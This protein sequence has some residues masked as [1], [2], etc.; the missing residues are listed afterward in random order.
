MKTKISL[1]V[2]PKKNILK[3]SSNFI[4]KQFSTTTFPKKDY[5]A[6]LG[7]SHTATIEEVKKA[8]RTLAKK[9][10]P[11]VSSKPDTSSEKVLALEKFRDVAE[12]YA[13]LSNSFSKHNYDTT[14]KPKPDAVYNSSKMTAKAMED[15]ADRRNNTGDFRKVDYEKGSYGDFKM[16]KLKEFQKQFNFDHL[17][18]FK[19]GV[20]RRHT[21]NRGSAIGTPGQVYSGY[22]HDDQHAD[23]PIVKPIQTDEAINHKYF[24]L[25]KKEQNLRFKPYFNIEKVNEDKM[26]EL[27]DEYR[28][29]TR[30]P[31]LVF[32]GLVSYY[33]LNKLYR[34][35]QLAHLNETAASCSADEYKMI[36]PV[37][38]LADKFKFN[39]KFLT[40]AENHQWIDND[41]R[42]FH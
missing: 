8:Y 13:V 5:Y 39:K 42:T 32:V 36:G 23:N 21:Y 31:M 4:F 37:M 35:Y 14:Y 10:H 28:D 26:L 34:N 17:G 38:V 27:T 19:G 33:I 24:N 6:I 25:S 20:P 22:E 12:A 18:N 40:R 7:L 15:S 3:Q 1:L 29:L 9:Y 2:I 11:D 16:E 30:W 41:L